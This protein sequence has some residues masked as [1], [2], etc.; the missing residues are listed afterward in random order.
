MVSYKLRYLPSFYKEMQEAVGYIAD[1]L[2]NPE[3]E[4]K[5]MEVRRFLYDRRNFGK[6]V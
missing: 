2:H 4:N 1:V 3:N 5:V 6:L